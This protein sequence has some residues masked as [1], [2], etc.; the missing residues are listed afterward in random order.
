MESRE[1]IE[2]IIEEAQRAYEDFLMASWGISRDA[3]KKEKLMEKLVPWSHTDYRKIFNDCTERVDDATG[4]YS[5]SP[6]EVPDDELYIC[7][8][9][10]TFLLS[11]SYTHLTLPT[12]YS[13]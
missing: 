6:P 8:E 7:W 11:V 9:N 3:A 5:M 2:E 4:Q 13:V 10:V 12:I 1:I